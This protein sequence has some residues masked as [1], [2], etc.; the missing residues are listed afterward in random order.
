MNELVSEE[1]LVNAKQNLIGKID[2]QSQR[3]SSIANRMLFDEMYGMGFDERLKMRKKIN[4]VTR[5]EIQA[6]A[7]KIFSEKHLISIVH[8]QASKN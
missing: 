2:I 7:K 5:S 1:E 6:L 3:N 8:G 4:S